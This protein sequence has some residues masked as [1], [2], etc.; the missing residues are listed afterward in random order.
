MSSQEAL[1]NSIQ[2]EKLSICS[3]GKSPLLGSQTHKSLWC[4][5]CIIYSDCLAQYCK[6]QSNTKSGRDELST[7]RFS[8]IAPG[9][10]KTLG[11]LELDRGIH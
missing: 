3:D 6:Q 4:V 11:F 7:H 10:L 1:S 9:Q 8:N 2:I 5:T